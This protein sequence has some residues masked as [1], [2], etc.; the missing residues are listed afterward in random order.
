MKRIYQKVLPLG[1]VLGVFAVNQP[2][3]A[4]DS[5]FL[6]LGTT[7]E[8]KMI[9]LDTETIKGTRFAIIMSYGDGIKYMHYKASCAE[10]RLFRRKTEIFASNGVKVS[11][12]R[13]SQE[14]KY[15]L[16]SAAGR[17]MNYVCKSVNAKGW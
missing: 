5:S 10:K 7:K 16:T 14:V 4:N 15:R 6:H 1:L 3:F 13:D 17:G 9:F 12:D 11:T 2:V 8:N